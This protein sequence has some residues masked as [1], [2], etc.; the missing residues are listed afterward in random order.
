MGRQPGEEEEEEDVLDFMVKNDK[1]EEI[2]RAM[3]PTC[4]TKLEN[5]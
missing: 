1:I 4:Q 2:W 3:I 5:T